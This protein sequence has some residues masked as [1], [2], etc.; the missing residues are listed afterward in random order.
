MIID[1]LVSLLQ[2]SFVDIDWDRFVIQPASYQA[3]FCVG[4]CQWPLERRDNTTKH[5]FVQGI[6]SSRNPEFI[7]PPCCVPQ[8]LDYLLVSLQQS[9]G[10]FEVKKWDD[11]IARSCSCR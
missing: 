3:N 6:A 1:F 7:P 8:D 9:S 5:S 11:M 2:V 10:L 4:S